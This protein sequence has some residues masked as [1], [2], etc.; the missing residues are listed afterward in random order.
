MQR[1]IFLA[2]AAGAVGRRLVPLLVKAGHR[3]TGTTRS[4]DRADELRALGAAP[5]VVDV[6]DVTALRDMM[7]VTAPDV[8]IH[9]LTDLSLLADPARLE[10]ALERN[11]KLRIEGTANLVAAALLSGAGRIIAQSISFVYAPGQQPYA[12]ST[13]LDPTADPR[14]AR[15]VAGV[16][17]LEREVTQTPGIEGIVLRY[18]HFYGPGTGRERTDAPPAGVVHVDAAAHAA[19]LAVD[20]GRAGIYNIA[21]DD[22]EVSIDKARTELGFDPGFRSAN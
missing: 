19:F 17:A 9:Q 10:E 18:G 13:P 12:E 7:Q 16:A 4:K 11:A 3:V 1:S 8:V 21:E 14:R 6:F 20:R 15:T 5:A 2:G 22:G